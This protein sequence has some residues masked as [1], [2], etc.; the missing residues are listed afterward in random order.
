[1]GFCGKIGGI[2]SFLTSTAKLFNIDKTKDTLT[3]QPIETTIF[4][5][6]IK[7]LFEPRSS[8]EH[9]LFPSGQIKVG[10]FTALSL[11]EVLE[12]QILEIK[13]IKYRV[14]A[15]NEIRYR[16]QVFYW[17]LHLDYYKHL[18]S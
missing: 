2:R 11:D 3:G 15:N 1:M 6:N 9:R 14:V 8:D 12:Q 5:K 10:Q 7:V 18:N 17:M 13:N 4:V 16:T